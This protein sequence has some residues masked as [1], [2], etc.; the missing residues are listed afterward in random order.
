MPDMLYVGLQDDDKIAVDLPAPALAAVPAK[1]RKIICYRREHVAAV[2]PDIAPA[3]AI[4]IHGISE[5]GRGHE[6]ALPH[7]SRPLGS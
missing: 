6:L 5:K 2:V 3:V 4:V 1:P 7:R